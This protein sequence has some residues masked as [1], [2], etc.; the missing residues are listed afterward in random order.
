MGIL[1]LLISG[2]FSLSQEFFELMN[3]IRDG[4]NQ[5]A[6]Y[7]NPGMFFPVRAPSSGRVPF[8][9]ERQR[10]YIFLERTRD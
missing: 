8:L 2:L 9:C 1:F 3:S 10:A 6:G 4:F 5:S 7:F